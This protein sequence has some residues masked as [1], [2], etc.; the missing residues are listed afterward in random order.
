MELGRTKTCPGKHEPNW[1][2][3][4][5]RLAL[6]NGSTEDTRPLVVEVWNEDAPRANDNFLG[7]VTVIFDSV[8]WFFSSAMVAR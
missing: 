7:Q 8:L 5:F 1:A 6:H 4:R 3:E 2:E